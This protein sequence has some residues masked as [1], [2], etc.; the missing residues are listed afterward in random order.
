[1]FQ[2]NLL[3]SIKNDE[4][5]DSTDSEGENGDEEIYTSDDEEALLFES[6]HENEELENGHDEEDSADEEEE[7]DGED[8]ESDETEDESDSD[9]PED[10]IVKDVK[11]KVAPRENKKKE[12]KPTNGQEA[13]RE[14]MKQSLGL[15]VETNGTTNGPSTTIQGTDI[16]EEFKKVLKKDLGLSKGYDEYADGDTSDEED[17]RNTVGNIPMHWYDEYNHIGYDWDGKKIMKPPQRDRLDEFLRQMEDPNFWRTVKD[18]QT[19][20]DVILSNDDIALIKRIMAQRNPDQN[21]TEYAPWIEWFTNEVEQL[22]IRNIPDHKR[23]FLPSKGEKL[24]VGR[25]V[26]ALKMGW[27]KTRAEEARIRKE[28]KQ[29]KFYMLWETDHGREKMRRIHDHVA[30]P[31]RALPGHAESYNPPPEYLF[32][33]KEI[34]EWQDLKEEPHKR[35][36]HF[37]PRK[38]K[39]LREVPYYDRYIRERFLRCLDLYLCPRAKRMRVTVQPEDLIPKLPSP[40]DLQPFPTMQNLIYRGHTG[41]IRCISIEPRGEYL[42][43]GSDDMTVKSEYS[44]MVVG[45]FKCSIINKYYPF[46]FGKYLQHVVLK[47]SKLKILYVQL[48]GVQIRNCHSLLLLVVNKC[49]SSI[50]ELVINYW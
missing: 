45:V 16:V 24:Q 1:M 41:I 37:L 15:D 32:N 48:H 31:K 3:T 8:E 7:E 46:Q 17:I 36:L 26:H 23:S 20:Q 38:Y 28:R 19:G 35:K 22:P 12:D 27:A 34:Q 21:F 43:S 47:Q 10:D 39:S 5:D 18:P 6:D 44:N 42:V 9:V 30:A 25:L 14:H 13:F 50:Q 33:N 29:P 49:C 4:G 2:E 40:K 11:K